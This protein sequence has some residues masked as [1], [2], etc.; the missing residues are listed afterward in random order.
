VGS[1][2]Q[3]L[4]EC[5]WHVSGSLTRGPRFPH[6]SFQLE[7]VGS[8]WYVESISNVFNV[9]VPICLKVP[10]LLARWK[11]LEA[12]MDLSAETFQALSERFQA[13]TKR[14]LKAER[15]AQSKRSGD[16]SAMD[17]YDTA[18]AKCMCIDYGLSVFF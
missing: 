18:T 7:E 16:S 15:K 11:R 2:E 8:D 4:T 3:H 10:S 5:L 12:G 9:D 6:E 13:N 14:W 17:I 1:T